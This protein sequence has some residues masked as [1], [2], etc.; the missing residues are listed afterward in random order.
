MAAGTATRKPRATKV[1]MQKRAAAENGI[2][3][4]V[5][6]PSEE[7]D[8]SQT[9]TKAAK[10]TQ[11]DKKARLAREEVAQI[12]AEAKA[13]A[14]A[15]AERARKSSEIH[16]QLPALFGEVN[17]GLARVEALRDSV[18][19]MSD[20]V[21]I[22][23]VRYAGTLGNASWR[24][25]VAANYELTRRTIIKAKKAAIKVPVALQEV[26]NIFGISWRTLYNDAALQKSFFM[27]AEG[28]EDDADEAET[29]NQ[30]GMACEILQDKSY[31]TIALGAKNNRRNAYLMMAAERMINPYFG[32]KDAQDLVK[33][34]NGKGGDLATANVEGEE[35]EAANQ[36]AEAD[37]AP[38]AM[39]GSD[40][41]SLASALANAEQ[42]AM[43]TESEWYV[44]RD[45]KGEW[46]S[47]NVENPDPNGQTITIHADMVNGRG[48]ILLPGEEWQD[49]GELTEPDPSQFDWPEDAE[50]QGDSLTDD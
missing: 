16:S 30:L 49:E 36:D 43:E 19:N 20:S 11:A 48:F 21:L 10:E 37:T 9:A 23:F 35:G 39:Q 31:A 12:E 33:K 34:L 25:Q 22:E 24:A 18:A 42:N 46:G 41:L 2:A 17:Q 8:G 4:E 13:E 5:E 3:G 7:V 29:L 1:E 27:P 45:S 15:E 47:F 32:I 6:L 14:E 50:D 38:K 26:A 28:K 44:W 40:V